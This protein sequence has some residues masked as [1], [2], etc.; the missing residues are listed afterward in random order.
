MA[1]LTPNPPL[2]KAHYVD[3]EKFLQALIDHKT[4]CEKAV[5][6][7]VEKPTVP[8]Y[9]GECFIKIATHLSYRGN[10]INYSFRDEMIS[11]AIENCFLAVEKFNHE[12]YKNPFAYYTQISFYAFVR[13][14]QREKSEQTLKY[15]L[16]KNSDI[17]SIITQEHDDAD[18]H[19]RQ[20][21]DYIKRQIDFM[22]FDKKDEPKKEKSDVNEIVEEADEQ[23]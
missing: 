18:E 4:Q 21:I 15:K 17:E 12:K 22:D 10:F 3:N 1:T 20:I 9:L 11:D 16:I 6:E 5:A 23:D 2:K 8:R 13:R 14:I 19:G 7:G